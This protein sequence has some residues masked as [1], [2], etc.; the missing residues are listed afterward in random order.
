MTDLIITEKLNNIRMDN[1]GK[2]H[3]KDAMIA[4]LADIPYKRRVFGL[5]LKDHYIL[6]CIEGY[7]FS[8]TPIH[9]L[10]VASI[11]EPIR[12][13]YRDYYYSNKKTSE[14]ESVDVDPTQEQEAI[15]YLKSLGYLIYKPV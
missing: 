15:K 6:R 14:P 2:F 9:N 10:K 4:L 8:N 1:A 12:K 13:Y 7:T 5:L 11:F 3:S